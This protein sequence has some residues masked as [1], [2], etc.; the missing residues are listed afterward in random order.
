MASASRTD[1][2]RSLWPFK[3][4]SDK[5]PPAPAK[6]APV[7]AEAPPG[8][9]FRLQIEKAKADG[10]PVSSLLLQLTLR[11][12]SLLKR[13]NRL[14]PGDISF[15]DGE[16]H[17]LGVKIAQGKNATSELVILQA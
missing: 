14:P 12:A 7:I 16:M 3:D 11:D 5:S 17:Y 8:E 13:D 15:I 10:A 2:A 6:P 1:Q 9:R 4:K